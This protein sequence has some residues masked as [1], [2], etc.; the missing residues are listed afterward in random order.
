LELLGAQSKSI[1]RNTK[2]RMTILMKQTMKRISSVL[3]NK[4]LHS[5]SSRKSLPRLTKLRKIKITKLLSHCKDKSK[6]NRVKETISRQLR[7]ICRL[8]SLK[9]W[10]GEW[11]TKIRKTIRLR[12]NKW[13]RTKKPMEGQ[14]I[15]ESSETISHSR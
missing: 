7:R 6:G 3:E 9:A 1:N 10:M 12:Y 14:E 13:S 4:M 5:S 8:I 15:R 2:I 11:Q